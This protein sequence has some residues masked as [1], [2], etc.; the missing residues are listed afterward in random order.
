MTKESGIID[1]ATGKPLENWDDA[2]PGQQDEIR[3]KFPELGEEEQE[4]T[5]ISA[6]RGQEYA[7]TSME[8]REY[9]SSLQSKL[10]TAA[11]EFLAHPFE[12][13]KFNPRIARSDINEARTI[14][15]NEI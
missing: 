3:R 2:S 7:A 10:E 5:R 14:Y 1:R 6:A 11:N 15:Y 8:K 9:Q 12:S 13:R 4:R